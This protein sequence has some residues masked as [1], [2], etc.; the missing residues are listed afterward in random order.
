MDIRETA[1]DIR[2]RFR[3]KKGWVLA[4]GPSLNLRYDFDHTGMRL[5]TDY[6]P[7]VAISGRGQTIIFLRPYE[8]MRE[9]LRPRDFCFLGFS[10]FCSPP[11][12]GNLD[13]HQHTSGATIQTGYFK[14]ATLGAGYY[15][16][17]GVNFVAS[18]AS[19][20]PI[21]DPIIDPLWRARTAPRPASLFGP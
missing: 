11:N 21:I 14:K 3:P 19:A 4:W 10:V 20:V 9:R 6:A 5:D 8:E 1:Q 2:Y 18:P 7:Y 15:W 13:Y 17:D 12:P 16:G